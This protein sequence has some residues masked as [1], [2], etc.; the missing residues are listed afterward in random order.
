MRLS[1]LRWI[2]SPG[3]HPDFHRREKFWS[4][5]Q[6]TQGIRVATRHSVVQLG[7]PSWTVTLGRRDSTTGS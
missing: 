5:C 2:C 3:R 7:G 1:G 6:F 4:Q